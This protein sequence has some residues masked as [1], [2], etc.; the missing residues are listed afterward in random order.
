MNKIDKLEK[1]MDTFIRELISCQSR[2]DGLEIYTD[3]TTAWTEVYTPLGARYKRMVDA[4]DDCIES[5]GMDEAYSIERHVKLKILLAA[6][7]KFQFL[8]RDHEPAD[9]W[10]AF[11]WEEG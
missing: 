10:D 1:A 8:L 7:S 5:D 4:A 9:F 11:N 2:E 6:V 3:E